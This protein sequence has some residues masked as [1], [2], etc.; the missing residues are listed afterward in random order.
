MIAWLAEEIRGRLSERSL[1]LTAILYNGT[2]SGDLIP[3][4]QLDEVGAEVKLLLSNPVPLPPDLAAFLAELRRLV[5]AA[6]SE[7]N[8][9]VFI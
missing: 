9:V 5:D 8:P 3:C 4:E 7:R 2:H 1:L 6:R